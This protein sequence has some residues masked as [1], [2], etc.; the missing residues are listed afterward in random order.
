MRNRRSDGTGPR[1]GVS[2]FG[3]RSRA[4]GL[5]VV[6]ALA[7]TLLLTSAPAQAATSLA[8][9]NPSFESPLLADGTPP[10]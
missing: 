3:R 2:R 5:A 10:P 4:C 1:S 8:I 6:G 9:D 7:A